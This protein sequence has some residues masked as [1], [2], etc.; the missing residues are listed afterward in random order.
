MITLTRENW[1]ARNNEVLVQAWTIDLITGRLRQV[2]AGDENL[3]EAT[4]SGDGTVVFSLTTSGKLLRTDML[5]GETTTLVASTV[6]ARAPQFLPIDAGG[7]LELSG[8]GFIGAVVRLNGE[9][10]PVAERTQ[11]RMIIEVP[12]TAAAGAGV[13][14]FE[15]PGSPYQPQRINVNVG[16][17]GQP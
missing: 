3:V 17:T 6:E 4:I 1:E 14:E 5:S 13:L 2:T 15:S 12:A 11:T 9:E 7:R 16:G 10:V 8:T